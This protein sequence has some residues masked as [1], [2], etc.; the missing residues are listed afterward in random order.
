MAYST[1]ERGVR[2]CVCVVDVCV[3]VCCGCDVDH[4]MLICGCDIDVCYVG[5]RDDM[6]YDVVMWM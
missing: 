4:V 5:M 2:V 1:A 3:C 6:Y